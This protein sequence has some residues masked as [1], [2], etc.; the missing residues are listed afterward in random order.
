M[1]SPLTRSGF[2]TNRN[3]AKPW[4]P[5]RVIGEGKI[6]WADNMRLGPQGQSVNTT[7]CHGTISTFGIRVHTYGP[8][9]GRRREGKKKR[10]SRLISTANIARVDHEHIQRL[11]QLRSKLLVIRSIEDFLGKQ[12]MNRSMQA[13]LG[14]IAAFIFPQLNAEEVRQIRVQDE[15]RVRSITGR[16]NKDGVKAIKLRRI[17][18]VVDKA[19]KHI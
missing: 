18:H 3:R 5:Q 11:L 16:L 6:Y 13:A 8:K 19:V 2:R 1:S 15:Q 7:G 17:M 10:G 14:K 4:R 12:I 9:K